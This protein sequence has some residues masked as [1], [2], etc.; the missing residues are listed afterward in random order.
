MIAVRR[1]AW[2]RGAMALAW[3]LVPGWVYAEPVQLGP[4]YAETAPPATLQA[5]P[6]RPGSVSVES[7]QPGA[8]QAEPARFVTDEAAVGRILE[9]ADQRLGVMPAVAAAKWQTH[10]PIYDPPREAAVIQRAA[11]LGSALGLGGEPLKRLFELQARLAREVQSL[12]QQAWKERGFSYAEPV[13]TLATLRPKLD[14]LTVD[15]LQALYIAAPVLQRDDFESHYQ[16]LAQQRLH[17]M[18]WTAQNRRELLQ[19]LHIVQVT[20]SAALQKISASGVLRVGTTGD[21]APFSLEEHGSLNG[22]DIELAQRLAAQLH[23]HAV[24]IH[25]SWGSLADDLSRGAFDV[26]MGGISIT[27]ARE[28]QGAFSVPYFS[29]GKTILARCSDSR[30][31]RAGI[32]SVDRAKVRVIVNPGGTNEQYVRAH[33]HHARI[34]VFPDNRGI[35][36][37]LSAGHADVMITDDIEAELQSRHYPGLC[38]VFSGTLTH[39]DKAILMPRDPDLVTAVNDWLTTAVAAGEPARVL[40]EYL[41]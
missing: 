6:A 39:A 36:S 37:E 5:E 18:G 29:G 26:A 15:L 28:A 10:A 19:A 16:E 33:I 1:S 35:F 3:T 27:P 24:F 8:A 30:R 32:G 34:V 17:A 41:Q 4:G 2:W 23:A 22:S 38:R 11:D 40:Q 25:T 12:L 7:A 20:S 14:G 13:T 31:F 9:L 21:Y